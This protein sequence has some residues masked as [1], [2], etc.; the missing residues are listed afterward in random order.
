MAG[1]ALVH[2]RIAQGR[3]LRLASWVVSNQGERAVGISSDNALLV[4]GAKI[5]AALRI[6]RDAIARW[7]LA[8]IPDRHHKLGPSGVKV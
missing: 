7:A 8:F 3:V 2:V 6:C 1:R 4:E 5:D